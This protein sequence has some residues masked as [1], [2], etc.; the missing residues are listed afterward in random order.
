MRIIQWL[1]SLIYKHNC[2]PTTDNWQL[3]G[4]NILFLLENEVWW[5]QTYF[6]RNFQQLRNRYAKYTFYCV[7]VIVTQWSSIL[8]NF[9]KY[10]YFFFSF[11]Q[12]NHLWIILCQASV[13]GY[14]NNSGLVWFCKFKW[15]WVYVNVCMYAATKKKHKLTRKSFVSSRITQP[16]FATSRT[17]L[18]IDSWFVSLKCTGPILFHVFDQEHLKTPQIIW[19]K[20][21]STHAQ[22]VTCNSLSHIQD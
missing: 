11:F 3:L 17:G 15:I 12:L 19:C 4:K 13:A 18:N 10:Q 1:F 6:S 2:V 9:D 5:F 16:C 21:R 7:F 14:G 20:S 8:N 22:Y